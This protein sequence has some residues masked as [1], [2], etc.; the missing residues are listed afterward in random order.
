MKSRPLI[1]RLSMKCWLTTVDTSMRPSC[2]S[3]TSAVTVTSSR[4]PLSPSVTSIVTA[5]PSASTMPPRVFVAN[6]DSSTAI[7]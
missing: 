4:V 7:V 2:T 3:G 1:G 6:P 5:C